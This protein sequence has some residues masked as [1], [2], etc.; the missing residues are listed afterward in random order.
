MGFIKGTIGTV[1]FWAVVVTLVGTLYTSCS[2]AA[3]ED[4][5]VLYEPRDVHWG[6]YEP[7]VLYLPSD[8]ECIQ[9]KPSPRIVQLLKEVAILRQRIRQLEQ[10]EQQEQ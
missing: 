2:Q 10:L 4:K 5:S 7:K 6:I 8:G 3:S 9:D 1:L